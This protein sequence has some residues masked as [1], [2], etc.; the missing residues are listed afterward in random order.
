MMIV[1]GAGEGA[2]EAAAAVTIGSRCGVG[3]HADRKMIAAM[4]T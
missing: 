3:A 2:G 4:M 1:V